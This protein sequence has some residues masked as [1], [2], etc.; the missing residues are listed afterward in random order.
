MANQAPNE[1]FVGRTPEQIKKLVGDLEKSGLSLAKLDLRKASAQERAEYI[2]KLQEIIPSSEAE[3]Q[4]AL[5]EI[6]EYSKEINAKKKWGMWEYAKSVP[7]RIW[8]TMK[9]HPYITAAVVIAL[10][11]AA[12]YYTGVGPVVVSKLKNWLMSTAFGQKMAELG[13]KAVQMGG[14]VL[15]KGK[16]LAGDAMGKGK[17]LADSA[18][19]KGKDLLADKI[20]GMG[21]AAP[22]VPPVAPSVPVPPVPPVA[23][24]AAPLP[25]TIPSL[26]EASKLLEASA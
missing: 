19:G 7:R 18:L 3:A 20:P 8:G 5:N 9:R 14:E 11:A 23:P 15:D 16:E 21:D 12:A 1:K 26:E 4:K 25:S 2:K 10:G 13:G 22:A 17:E 24:G 6:A